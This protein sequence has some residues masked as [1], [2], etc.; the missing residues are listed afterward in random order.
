MPEG[1]Q[2][3]NENSLPATAIEMNVSLQL[4]V[5]YLASLKRYEKKA[6]YQ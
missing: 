6:R 5:S 2:L 4:F 1:C 3:N